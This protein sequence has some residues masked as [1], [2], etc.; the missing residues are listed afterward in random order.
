MMPWWGLGD[1]ETK[2][3]AFLTSGIDVAM[4]SAVHSE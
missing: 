3:H 4:Q 1:E 2:H